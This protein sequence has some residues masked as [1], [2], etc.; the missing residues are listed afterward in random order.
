MTKSL[1]YCHDTTPNIGSFWGI[2]PYSNKW[3]DYHNL[4]RRISLKNNLNWSEVV[5]VKPIIAKSDL[6]D[7]FP[8]NGLTLVGAEIKP[9]Y[10]N[11]RLDLLYLRE[12]G[13]L[14]PCELKIGGD[15][16]DTHGQLIRYMADLNSKIID[17]D[18]LKGCRK[19]LERWGDNLGLSEDKFQSFIQNN[20]ITDRCLRLL[21]ATGIIIDEGFPSQMLKAVRFLNSEHGFS[22]RLLEIRAFVDESWTSQ[23]DEYLMR[24]DFVDTD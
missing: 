5:R 10:E 22:V 23:Q 2:K 18:F 21:P 4:S 7:D 12:D 13:G 1:Y 6:W 3:S 9:G 24:I 15:S 19:S 16:K 8:A 17:M 14:I 11:Q 20:S